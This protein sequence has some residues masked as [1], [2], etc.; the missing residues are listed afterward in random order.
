MIPDLYRFGFLMPIRRT[1]R[2]MEQFKI[3]SPPTVIVLPLTKLELKQMIDLAIREALEAHSFNGINLPVESYLTRS[4]VAQLFK[5][6]LTAINKWSRQGK[7]KRHYI[8]SR[9]YFLR[10]EIDSLFKS[11]AERRKS[12]NS[13]L[14]PITNNQFDLSK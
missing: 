10:S 9:V 11:T 3:D 4:E 7:L 12:P 2:N 1:N 14:K 5:V 13:H 6:T 8:G